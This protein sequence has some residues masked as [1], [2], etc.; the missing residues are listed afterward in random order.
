[1]RE[2]ESV[3]KLLMMGLAGARL[4]PEERRALK[5][6]RPA[7]VI[8]FRR[9][10]ESPRQLLSLSREIASLLPREDPP[11]VGIDQEGG[12]VA[13][14]GDPFTLFPGNDFLGRAYAQTGKTDL[15]F[16]QARAMARELKA[17]GVNLNFT[18]VAEV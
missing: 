11:L 2:T 9:N 17:I 1:M 3:G 10:V 15:A 5:E 4:L 14:L 8:Y 7:G 16:R 13:R 6:V 12:R 18:P